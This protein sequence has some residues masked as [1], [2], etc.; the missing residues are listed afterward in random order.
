MPNSKNTGAAGSHVAGVAATSKHKFAWVWS[1][2]NVICA[3]YPTNLDLL[4]K[5]ENPYCSHGPGTFNINPLSGVDGMWI[6]EQTLG[7]I[8]D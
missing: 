1:G 8:I 6:G 2:D 3:D 5:P 7:S 4:V